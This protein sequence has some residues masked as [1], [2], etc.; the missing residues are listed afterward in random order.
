MREPRLKISGLGKE[1]PKGRSYEVIVFPATGA[2]GKALKRDIGPKI[3]V[4]EVDAHIND[5]LF[6]ETASILLDELMHKV[7]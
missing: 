6:A 3:D 4:V 2:G 7:C 1:I 5:R